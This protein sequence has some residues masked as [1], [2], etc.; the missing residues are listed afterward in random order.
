M[1]CTAKKG[2]ETPGFPREDLRAKR[3]KQ[4]KDLD[5]A[6][7]PQRIADDIKEKRKKNTGVYMVVLVHTIRKTP[8]KKEGGGCIM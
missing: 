2:Q 7:K 5:A 8:K 1:R 4:L 6:P 3:T